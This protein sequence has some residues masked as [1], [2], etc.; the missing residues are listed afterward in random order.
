LEKNIEDK[1]S[2]SSHGLSFS[3]YFEKLMEETS[4]EAD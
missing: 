1:G 4:S 2:I 3:D